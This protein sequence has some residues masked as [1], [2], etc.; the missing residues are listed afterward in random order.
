M[1][2]VM[3]ALSYR[4]VESTRNSKVFCPLHFKRTYSLEDASHAIKIQ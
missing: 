1:G 4:K 2:T 3:E